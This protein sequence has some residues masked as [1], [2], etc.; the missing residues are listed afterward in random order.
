MA[1]KFRTIRI[2]RRG[3]TL[4]EALVA[5][6]IREALEELG[7]AV[8]GPC[9]RMTDAMVALRHNRIDAAVL[10]VNLGD[11]SVYPLADM[12]VAESIPFIFVT[13]YGAE[14]LDRRF[15][16]VPVLQKPI[17]RHALQTIFTHSPKGRIQ[18]RP[19]PLDD[20]VAS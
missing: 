11:A 4:V 16:T 20:A 1:R 19:A 18:P 14:E 13:G 2:A 10:D 15:L 17:E 9:N 3:F 5:I 6:A 7:Y 8:V 12:L